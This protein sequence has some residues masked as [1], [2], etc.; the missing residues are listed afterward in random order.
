MWNICWHCGLYRVDKRIDPNGP[1]AISPECGH[2]HP[3]RQLPLLLVSG[4]SGAGKSTVCQ[5][6]MGQLAEVVLL[7]SDILWR[8]E[9]NAPAD[10]YQSFFETWLRMC[11]N[12]GQAG[13][14]VVLF[15]AGVGVPANLEGCIERRYFARLHYLALICED[16]VLVR[17]LEQRPDWRQS[18][19]AEVLSEQVQFNGWFKTQGRPPQPAVDLIDT[20]GLPIATTVEQV[21]A[22]IQAKI[23]L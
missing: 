2:R 10:H 11:K 9:F 15:G 12:I 20:T 1:A 16:E 23:V 17:R 5:A 3:F 4:A 13:R 18:R 8:P 21:R 6:L 7:D 22:W 14:P 19:S